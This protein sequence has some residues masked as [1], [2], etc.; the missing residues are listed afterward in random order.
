MISTQNLGI[1]FCPPCFWLALE[2][3]PFWPQKVR[4][5]ALTY[6]TTY[7]TAFLRTAQFIGNFFYLVFEHSVAECNFCAFLLEI[8]NPDEIGSI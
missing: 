1:S 2:Q 3:L 6:R 4:S 5:K 8:S 7:R